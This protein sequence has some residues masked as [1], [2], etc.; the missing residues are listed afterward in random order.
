MFMANIITDIILSKQNKFLNDIYRNICQYLK[1]L[2]RDI[3]GR[4]LFSE[5]G[6]LE[7]KHTMTDRIV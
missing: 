7:G 3:A 4:Y 2:G 6:S 1:I 5:G